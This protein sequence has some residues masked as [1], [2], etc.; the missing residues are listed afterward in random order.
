M[1]GPSGRPLPGLSHPWAPGKLL[2]QGLCTGRAHSL[3]HPLP[4]CRVAPSSALGLRTASLLSPRPPLGSLLHLQAGP[5][6]RRGCGSRY[7][8][9][10][11]VRQTVISPLE[12]KGPAQGRRWERLL[13]LGD[14]DGCHPAC[15]GRAFSLHGGPLSASSCPS[16]PLSPGGAAV[17]EGCSPPVLEAALSGPSVSQLGAGQAWLSAHPDRA[18]LV[19]QCWWSRAPPFSFPKPDPQG[20]R[21]PSSRGK[22][23]LSCACLASCDGRAGAPSSQG[24]PWSTWVPAARDLGTRWAHHRCRSLPRATAPQGSERLCS[25]ASRKVPVAP[26]SALDCHPAAA[27]H[28]HPLPVHLSIQQTVTKQLSALALPCAACW[29][30]PR[31]PASVGLAVP[32]QPWAPPL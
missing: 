29:K 7:A 9:P 17:L 26:D 15:R 28:A 20:P 23:S 25:R 2:P 18:P 19:I 6:S 31:S 27:S 3:A 11:R 16:G 4:R 1:D 14:L 10:C 12:G 8:T 32:S 22:I 21:P 5:F 13:P 30:Q 24:W